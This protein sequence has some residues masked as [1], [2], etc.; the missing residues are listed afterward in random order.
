MRISNLGRLFLLSVIITT[1]GCV[2]SAEGDSEELGGG[3][4]GGGDIA[5]TTTVAAGTSQSAASTGAGGSA[6]RECDGFGLEVVAVDYGPGAGFGQSSMPDIV[7][8]APEGAGEMMGSL[9]VVTLGNGGSITLAFGGTIDDGPGPDFIVFENAF[10][11]GGDPEAAF[12]EIASVEVSEDG[13][14]WAAYPCTATEA[15]FDGCSGW[16]PTYAGSDPEID[17]HDPESA[18][19]E[20][21]DL[22]DLGLPSARFVRITDRAD[23]DGFTGLFDLDAVALVHWTCDER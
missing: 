22:S 16:H 5:T 14:T 11:A 1:A 17:P 10:Y 19:G 9:D 23:L 8:G 13:Q 12:A 2:E 18:G 4:A 7:L 21:F 20:A 3:G 15:P 6:P